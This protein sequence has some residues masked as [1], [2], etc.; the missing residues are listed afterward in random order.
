V[1][2]PFTTDRLFETYAEPEKIVMGLAMR[3]RL[4]EFPSCTK[5]KAADIRGIMRR[6]AVGNFLGARKCWNQ[7]PVDDA[8]LAQFEADCICAREDGQAV[9][10]RQV[11]AYI[12]NEVHA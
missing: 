11:I 3:C 1:D 12:N 2:K 10:I 6:V 7:C 9:E 8:A 4:C 5:R